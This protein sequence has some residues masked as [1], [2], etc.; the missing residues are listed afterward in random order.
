MNNGENLE[1]NFMTAAKFS[2]DIEEIVKDGHGLVNYI[3]AIICYCD[4]N[5]IELENVPKL[6]SKPLKE[7]LKYQAQN[8]N[9]MKKTT[10]GILPL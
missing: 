7:K 3:D 5:D 9:F 10:R 6:I 1:V 8:L 4:D 2:S